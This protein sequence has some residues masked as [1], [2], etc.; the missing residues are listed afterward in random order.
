MRALLALTLLLSA[1][2]PGK[3]QAPAAIPA[4][5]VA[6]CV[7]LGGA[8][9]APTEGEWGYT[10]R[11]ADMTRIREAGFDAVRIPVK[12]TAHTDPRPPYAIDPD[13]LARVD[14]VIAW[15]LAA[16][17]TVIVNVHHDE[18]VSEDA[19]A[20][21]PRLT[22]IWRQ[23]SQ[24]WRGA[25]DGLVFEFLN[26]PHSDLT[27]GRIDEM[28][29]ELLGLV[30][31]DHPQRWVVLPSGHWGHLKGLLESSPPYDPRAMITFHFYDPFDFTH[32]GAQWIDPPKPAGASWGSEKD[33]RDILASLDRAA[34][35]RDH[36]GLP[37]LLGEFGVYR[38]AAPGARAEWTG[39]VRTAAEERG[40]GWCY[41]EW[42]TGFPVYDTA[43]ESWIV[44]VRE[45]LITP[46]TPAR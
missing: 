23:L 2:G 5:P 20:H 21:L 24:H 40:F 3:A 44:A 8:L 28:N 13:F 43:T 31:G 34:A 33:R 29:R 11:R 7:N 16:G 10:I 17:L 25:P 35:F 22:A 42:A 4:P 41:W 39:F 27:P 14:E 45:A 9:E 12:W 18:E 46:P 26:E 15:G 30:R 1:C 36:A 38:E 37:L 32:Q 6:R 19:D